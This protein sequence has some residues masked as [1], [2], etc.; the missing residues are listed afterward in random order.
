MTTLTFNA[1]F[2]IES[3]TSGG[4]IQAI[5]HFLKDAKKEGARLTKS[6]Q[7]AAGAR[8]KQESVDF[9]LAAGVAGG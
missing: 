3:G 8:E 1:R 6:W 4:Q 9:G 2:P 7:W 5:Y